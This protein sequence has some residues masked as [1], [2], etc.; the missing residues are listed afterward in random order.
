M[1]YFVLKRETAS[2]KTV[3]AVVQHC[4]TLLDLTAR[5]VCLAWYVSG[6]KE[7]W[8]VLAFEGVLENTDHTGFSD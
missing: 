2:K 4:L 5:M 6:S 7:S 3:D 8:R 1:S